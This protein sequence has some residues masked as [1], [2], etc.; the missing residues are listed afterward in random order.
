TNAFLIGSLDYWDQNLIAKLQAHSSN[1]VPG[2]LDKVV[3]WDIPDDYK[4]SDI[5]I[6][7]CGVWSVRS[8]VAP[9][10][11]NGRFQAGKKLKAPV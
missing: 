9:K 10:L 8:N 6:N 5:E 11:Y 2:G 7:T 1:L 3:Q 4:S